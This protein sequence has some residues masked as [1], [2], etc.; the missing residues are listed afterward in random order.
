MVI[1]YFPDGNEILEGIGGNPRGGSSLRLDSIER[2]KA[3]SLVGSTL[4]GSNSAKYLSP[5]TPGLVSR[6]MNKRGTELV[7]NSN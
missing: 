7:K 1:D 3:G 4:N 5:K 2:Q 6:T